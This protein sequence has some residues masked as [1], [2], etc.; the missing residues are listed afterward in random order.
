MIGRDGVR[1]D[2][3]LKGSGRTPYSRGGDGR[4]PLGPVLREYIVSEAMSALGVPTTRAL[5]AV[6]TGEWV[7]RE[8]RSCR[9][10]CWRGWH[11]AISASAPSSSLPRSRDHGCPATAGRACD[12]SATIHK[13]RQADNPYLRCSTGDWPQAELIARWQLLG[14]IHGVMNTDNML[15]SGE[16]I[17]YGPCAFMDEFDP[18]KVFSSIDQN[19][20]YAYRNQP[21]IAHWNLAC[22]PRPCYRSA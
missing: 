15:L 4:A 16:T 9:A 17:D 8:G 2:I 21:G 7:V 22:W 12:S 1:Y 10:P 14:F 6:T 13:R 5:A 18:D 20:R 11:K 3:Q 19:G